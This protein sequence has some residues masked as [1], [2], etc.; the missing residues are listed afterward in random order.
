M[1]YLFILISLI[2]FLL[3]NFFVLI[4]GGR[5]YLG[6][7]PL[8]GFNATTI[9]RIFSIY[10]LLL[11]LDRM[12][13]IGL[14]SV[15]RPD[16]NLTKVGYMVFANVIGDLI[17]VWIFK[18]LAAMAIASVLFT[19]IGVWVGY[20]FLDKELQLD[21]RKVFSAGGDFYKSMYVK[22]TNSNSLSS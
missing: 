15:N 6:T 16:R 3:A 11:P 17:A 2:T 9:V 4:L 8:T 1:T 21:Y 19:A 12:T 10:G 18:S 7:D 13:G 14:D 5:Q 22:F 20:Y